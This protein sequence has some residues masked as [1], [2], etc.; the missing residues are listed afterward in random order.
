MENNDIFFSKK[1]KK[2]SRKRCR[3]EE[4]VIAVFKKIK[5]DDE[6][7]VKQYRRDIMLYT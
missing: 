2:N 1:K 3:D 5:I 7:D 4:I 6:K